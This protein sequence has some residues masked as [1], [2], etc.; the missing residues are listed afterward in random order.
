MNIDD[1]EKSFKDLQAY[2]DEQ[3]RTLN[4]LR[5]ENEALKQ[6]IKTLRQTVENSLNSSLNLPV[7][8]LSV[9]GISNEQLICETQ[10]AMLKEI[11]LTRQLTLEESR[12]VETFY[13]I[14]SGIR[15]NKEDVKDLQIEKLS[16][17]ELIS[18]ATGSSDVST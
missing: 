8:D 9:S 11:A 14:L 17:A 18:I 12:K 10:L 15:T 7:S 6:E 5:K 13:K 2:S 16:E 4:K 1:M 3:F